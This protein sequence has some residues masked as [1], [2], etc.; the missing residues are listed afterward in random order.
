[1]AQC[2]GFTA[3]NYDPVAWARLFK[4]AGA[5]YAILTTKRSTTRGAI[6]SRT[7]MRSRWIAL[8]AYFANA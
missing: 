8:S 1:M 2:A 6:K 4:E 3:A 7:T 5:R